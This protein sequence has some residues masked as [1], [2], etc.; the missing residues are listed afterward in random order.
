[1]VRTELHRL[2]LLGIILVS[3]GVGLVWLLTTPRL[4]LQQYLDITIDPLFFAVPGAILML[5]VA[6]WVLWGGKGE[7]KE[8]DTRDGS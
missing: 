2:I 1:M 7:D 4:S 5:A 6:R 8:D 3:M